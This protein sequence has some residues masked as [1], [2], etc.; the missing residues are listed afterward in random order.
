LSPSTFTNCC[1]FL[2]VTIEDRNVIPQSL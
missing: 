2:N 1:H